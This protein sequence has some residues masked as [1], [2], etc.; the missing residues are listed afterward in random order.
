MTGYSGT[1][2][3][4][5]LPGSMAGVG[6]YI[7]LMKPRVMSL[8]VFSGFAGL[9]VAPGDIH[10]LLAAVAL[11]CIALGSG[12]S[13]A[14]NMWF[15]RDIDALMQ[16]TSQRPLPRG[17]INPSEAL[18]F[19]I[20]LAGLSVMLMGVAV[21]WAAAGWLLVA[22]LFYV[23]IYTI[24][25][26]RRTPQNIVIGGAAGAFPP[27]IGWV[28]VTGHAGAGAWSL[29]TLIFLWTPPH[30]WALALTHCQDYA[31][32][33]IPMLPNVAGPART[34]RDILLYSLLLVPAGLA[35]VW[36]GVAGWV[37]GATA[38][39]SGL[40]F[41]AAAISLHRRGGDAQARRLF[42]FSIFYLFILLAMLVADRA[43]GPWMI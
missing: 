28:A 8:V 32:A 4:N 27:L 11:L 15:D 22:I 39:A 34:R 2:G 36:L 25:L 9:A 33:G 16:R 24:W 7:T 43:S 35:P 23:F 26:K 14:I 19:G 21:N 30:F 41:I 6:D 20:I 37:Y 3:N 13:G 1:A 29:F 5:V 40:L 18:S 31:R 12:A 38:L 17:V 42:G 10:P